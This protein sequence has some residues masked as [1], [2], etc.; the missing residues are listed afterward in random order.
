MELD[1]LTAEDVARQLKIKK[2]TVYE[3]IKRKELPSSK[4]GK[5]VRV[6]QADVNLYLESRKTGSLRTLKPSP[7]TA[8]PAEAVEVHQVQDAFENA[9]SPVVLCGQ[10][11]CLELLVSRIAAAKNI[12]V[13]RSYMGSYNGMYTFYNGRVSMTAAHLWDAETNTYNYPFIGR[14]LPGLSVGVLRLAG[15]TQGFYVKKGNPLGIW[16]WQDFQRSDIT[17]INRERG[18]GTRIL[19]DQKLKRLGIDPSKIRGYQQEYSSHL[20]C[21]ALV[22][23][24]KADMGCG[25]EQAAEEIPG[26]E[27]IPLQLEWYDLIFRLRDRN[28]PVIQEVLSYVSSA[29]FKQDLEIMG[30]YD[31]SQTGRYEEF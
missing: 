6:S 26:I 23:K 21:A 20:A 3:L 30:K 11:I 22:A 18:C 7:E 13:L 9:L 4:V 5:Q 31:L 25:C 15:R 10:D 27:F 12:Q 2:Y 29:E 28:T 24:G 16:D 17:M 8:Y 14:L 19:L 1:L